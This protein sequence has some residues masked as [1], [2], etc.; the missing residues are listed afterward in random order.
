[1]HTVTVELSFVVS[2][3]KAARV[4]EAW[5]VRKDSHKRY[6]RDVRSGRKGSMK[7]RGGDEAR[8]DSSAGE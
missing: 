1:M 4:L 3:V 2:P 5:W 6:M 8:A 7:K